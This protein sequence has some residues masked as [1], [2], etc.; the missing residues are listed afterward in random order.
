MARLDQILRRDHDLL[1]P[2]TSARAEDGFIEQARFEER[3]EIWWLPAKGGDRA[4]DISSRFLHHFWR[5]HLNIA[6]ADGLLQ[7]SRD[8]VLVTAEHYQHPLASVHL[9]DEG[10]YGLAFG[11][12]ESVRHVGR[13]FF[14]LR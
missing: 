2:L 9:K 3:S 4:D 12:A 14:R 5:R 7:I 8:G 11:E 10:F 1:A 13:A 6:R